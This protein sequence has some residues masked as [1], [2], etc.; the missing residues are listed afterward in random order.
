MLGRLRRRK[1]FS[2]IELLIVIAIIGIIATIAIPILLKVRQGAIREKAQNSLRSVV[3]AEFAYYSKNGTYA[4]LDALVTAGYIA[5]FPAAAD[6]QGIVVTA[7]GGDT[8][9]A[10]ADCSAQVDDT[11]NVFTADQTGA[12]TNNG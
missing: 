6:N 2:L 12:I 10:S 9:T 7:T 11:P 4:D 8:F 3:T 5:A 1:G